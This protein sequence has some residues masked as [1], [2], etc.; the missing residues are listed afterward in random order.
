MKTRT[1]VL[2]A[3]LRKDLRLFWPLALLIGGLRAASAIPHLIEGS[4]SI[5]ILAQIAIPLLTAFLVLVVLHEDP[6]VSLTH[7]WL[8]RP[9]P[10]TKLLVAKALFLV[11]AIFVPWILSRT[12]Y[13]LVQGHSLGESLLAGLTSGADRTQLLPILAL[14]AFAAITSGIR[15]AF[16]VALVG[17]AILM[18]VRLPR[19]SSFE[20]PLLL[21]ATGSGWVASEG[22]ALL[23]A[24][25]AGLVLWMQYRH[26]RTWLARGIASATPVVAYAVMAT[27]TWQTAF[28][29]QK[30]LSRDPAAAA[31][32]DVGMAENCFSIRDT[33]AAGV[34]R[35][36]D[37]RVA[38]DPDEYA[39]VKRAGFGALAFTT[40]LISHSIP[41]GHRLAVAHVDFSYQAESR[42]VVRPT[43]ISPRLV[44]GAGEVGIV[45]SNRWLLT[46]EEQQRLA[47]TPGVESHFV[48]SL[49]LLQPVAAATIEAGAPRRYLAGIGYCSATATAN[50][51]QTPPHVIH[52]DCFKPG[53][54]PAQLIAALESATENLVHMRST[55]FTPAAL[56]L[57]DGKYF[58]VALFTSEVPAPRVRLTAYEAR[59]HFDREIVV[60]GV[61]GGPLATCPLVPATETS[62]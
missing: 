40:R 38:L 54:Q 15:Q 36:G 46:L 56:E 18:L 32:V 9:I 27:I 59:A 25:G 49:S 17:V 34:S 21:S 58:N 39:S 44:K 11:L 5:A 37:Q 53:E 22:A 7:D 52:V 42:L 1:G 55:D 19:S 47:A 2:L 35:N 45:S 61:L 62:P 28:A 3:V 6:V 51:M 8:T 50:V 60:P 14:M 13:E 16:V 48:Y 43:N 23:L 20:G 33:A 26:R 29:V 10:G 4:D 31:L 24:L 41:E 12:V 57:W 30:S